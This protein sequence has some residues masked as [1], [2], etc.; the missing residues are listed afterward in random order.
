MLRMTL[1]QLGHTV[2][3]AHDGEEGLALFDGS[4]VD[5]LITDIIM[6]KK[7]GLQVL[8]ELRKVRPPVKIIAISGGGRKSSADYLQIA[9]LM[10]AGRVLAKPFSNEELVAA[11]E[12]LLGG[13][14]TAEPAAV[15]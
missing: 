11:I 10:G 15:S 2:I 4:G 6:P 14:A 7:E 9:K 5:L 12:E 3:E 13:G 1:A 8:M